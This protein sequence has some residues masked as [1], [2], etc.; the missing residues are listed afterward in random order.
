MGEWV[1]EWVGEWIGGYGIDQR[2]F[3]MHWSVILI[4]VFM[5]FLQPTNFCNPMYD[6]LLYSESNGDLGPLDSD[7]AEKRQ[8]LKTQRTP[9][10]FYDD[11]DERGSS[12]FT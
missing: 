9:P 12:S 5:L 3:R 6:S 1:G 4:I 11:D 2:L 8:L 10:N 7:K